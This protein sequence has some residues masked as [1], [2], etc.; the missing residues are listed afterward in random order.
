[1]PE[2]EVIGKS[3]ASQRAFKIKNGKRFMTDPYGDIESVFKVVSET[4]RLGILK[5]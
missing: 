2:V 1:M 3:D 4:K 5:R